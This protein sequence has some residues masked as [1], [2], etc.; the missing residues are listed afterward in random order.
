MG[1]GLDA[2]TSA[3]LLNG[4]RGHG[5]VRV[6]VGAGGAVLR[7]VDGGATWAPVASGTTS[8]LDA[9]AG[10][11]ATAV[12]V[13]RRGDAI[14]SD[15]GGERWRALPRRPE[16]LLAVTVADDGTAFATGPRGGLARLRDGGAW[17]VLASGVSVTLPGVTH[18]GERRSTQWGGRARGGA[19]RRAG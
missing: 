15:D 12:A 13:G 16:G 10:R 7:S 5:S 11:G 2:R 1:V 6:A 18:D 4:V 17:E 14:R 9:V 8:D 19:L 3:S